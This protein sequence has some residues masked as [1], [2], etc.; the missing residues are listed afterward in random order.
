[1][2]EIYLRYIGNILTEDAEA[3][4]AKYHCFKC[5]ENHFYGSELGQEHKRWTKAKQTK[6]NLQLKVILKQ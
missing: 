3:L 2:N 6:L 5:G 1:M 4:K